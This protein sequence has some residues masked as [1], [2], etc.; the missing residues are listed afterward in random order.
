MHYTKDKIIEL[1][2][3]GFSE[4]HSHRD[5]MFVESRYDN[6]A[7][8]FIFNNYELISRVFSERKLCFRFVP[9]VIEE[10]F[11]NKKIVDYYCLKSVDVS[12][13]N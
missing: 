11:A 13:A 1:K 2:N 9:K 10:I 6:Q 5:I 7:N 12:D 3:I 8:D 4:L